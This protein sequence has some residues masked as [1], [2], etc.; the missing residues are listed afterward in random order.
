VSCRFGSRCDLAVLAVLGCFWRFLA[1]SDWGFG[2]FWEGSGRLWRAS[3]RVLA[4][5]GEGNAVKVWH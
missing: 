1:G 2:G 3:G 5:S 4:G